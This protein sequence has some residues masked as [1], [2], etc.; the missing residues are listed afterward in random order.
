V[1]G[2]GYDRTVQE[3]NEL[4]PA[5]DDGMDNEDVL[6]ENVPKPIR[7]MIAYKGAI[8]ALGSTIWCEHLSCRNT[9][10]TGID[11]PEKVSTPAQHRQRHIEH[12]KFQC[13]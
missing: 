6:S 1:E 7:D 11:L 12:E 5:G 2:F 13:V 4:Y 3:L 8:E 10:K 9:Q